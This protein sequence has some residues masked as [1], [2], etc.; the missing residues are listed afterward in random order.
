MNRVA[1]EVAQ[2]VGMLFENDYV[3]SRPRKQKAKHHSSRSAAGNAAT[4]L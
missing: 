1:T 3:D 4:N 2:K